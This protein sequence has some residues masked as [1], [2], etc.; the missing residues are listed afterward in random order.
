MSGKD[1]GMTSVSREQSQATGSPLNHPVWER[2][3]VSM[4]ERRSSLHDSRYP[5]TPG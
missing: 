5:H 3:A 4:S 1:I 2:Q